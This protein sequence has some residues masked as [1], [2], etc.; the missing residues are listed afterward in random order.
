MDKA[1]KVEDLGLVKIE[2]KLWASCIRFTDDIWNQFK[3]SYI[4]IRDT[5]LQLVESELTAF[6]ILKS[7]VDKDAL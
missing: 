3:P 7:L 1:L 4:I 2:T 6:E 5:I